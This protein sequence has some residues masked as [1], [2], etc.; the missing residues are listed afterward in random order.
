M[1]YGPWSHA[2]RV[3]DLETKDKCFKNYELKIETLS[4]IIRD[5]INHMI[6]NNDLCYAG[7]IDQSDESSIIFIIIYLLFI[8]YRDYI[9]CKSSRYL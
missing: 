6:N 9:R 7:I 3:F 5:P 1:N 4:F 2:S 8:Y